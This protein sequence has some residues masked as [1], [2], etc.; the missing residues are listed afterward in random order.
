M[1]LL[2]VMDR[3]SSG[4]EACFVVPR[5]ESLAGGFPEL[6]KARASRSELWKD[7]LR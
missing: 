3:S 7:D 4:G 5:V 2:M 6:R 1:F